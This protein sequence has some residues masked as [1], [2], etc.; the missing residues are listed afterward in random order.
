MAYQNEAA[1]LLSCVPIHFSQG[2][3]F[4][5]THAG[6]KVKKNRIK[7]IKTQTVSTLL[8]ADF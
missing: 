6:K 4:N 5:V 8:D 7:Q 1:F 2:I 3:K